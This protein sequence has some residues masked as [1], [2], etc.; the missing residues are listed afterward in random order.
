[1]TQFEESINEISEV[2][3]RVPKNQL[4]DATTHLIGVINGM[5]MADEI[6]KAEETKK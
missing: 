1:M 2:L 4:R 5:V 6:R 3:K